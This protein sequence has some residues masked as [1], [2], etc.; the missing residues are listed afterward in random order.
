[1]SEITVRR[2][3]AQVIM[4]LTD[5]DNRQVEVTLD[6]AEAATLGSLL[7]GM[8]TG[9]KPARNIIP[10]SAA[11]SSSAGSIWPEPENMPPFDSVRRRRS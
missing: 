10:E 1:M 8:P 7:L 4:V 9:P 3:G 6:A 5:D 2:V 11:N